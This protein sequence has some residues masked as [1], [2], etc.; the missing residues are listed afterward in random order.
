MKAKDTTL[1]QGMFWVAALLLAFL[2]AHGL[3]LVLTASDIETDTA[4]FGQVGRALTRG[5]VLYRDIWDNKPPGIFLYMVPFVSLFGS[6]IRAANIAIATLDVFF[7]IAVAGIVFAATRSKAGAVL[8]GLIACLY[9]VT[10]MK[11]ESTVLMAALGALAM[12]CVIAARGRGWLLFLGGFLFVCGMIVKQPLVVEFPA[13]LLAALIFNDGRRW[14]TVTGLGAGLVTAGLLFTGWLLSTNT[15]GL[16]WQHTVSP[17]GRY[18]LTSEGN[19]VLSADSRTLFSTTFLQGTLPQFAPLFLFALISLILYFR[20]RRPRSLLGLAL[21]WLV[22]ALGAAA[23]GRN[24]KPAYYMQAIPPLMLL[25][26]LGLPEYKRLWLPAKGLILAGFIALTLNFGQAFVQ[27]LPTNLVQH[28]PTELIQF[29]R[30]HTTA[31]DCLWTWGWASGVT[32]LSDRADCAGTPSDGHVMDEYNFTIDVYRIQH[33]QNLMR[34]RPALF[35]ND[36]TWGFFPEL[37][38]YADRYLGEI[39]Y[40]TDETVVHAVNRDM[41]HAT[42][43]VFGSE[44][45][46]I[47]YDLLP[48]TGAHCP[49]ATL[50]MAMDWQQLR[51]PAHQYQMFVQILTNDEQTRVAGYDGIPVPKRPSNTWVNQGEVLLGERFTLNIPVD[52]AP[53]SYKLV[54]GLYDVETTERLPVLDASG[55]QTGTY[56]ILQDI[57]LDDTCGDA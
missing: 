12:A 9:A 26:S 57:V 23:V 32:Y 10:T 1:L 55:T 11:V 25:I 53:G 6:T 48:V 44:V 18:V 2:V 30:T 16:F 37:Q 40:E 5:S 14:R 22:L 42:H 36:G 13:L 7:G 24:F 54:V 19:W 4:F 3:H 27:P 43:V 15:L 20:S 52:T 34:T 41:W 51:T 28:R 46:L 47:G 33:M 8:S 56:A 31:E 49:G 50:E 21:F 39:V 17:V 35:V 45:A 38:R 29:I